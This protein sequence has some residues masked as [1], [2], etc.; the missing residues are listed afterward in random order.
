MTEETVRNIRLVALDLDDT[1][2]DSQYKLPPVNKKAV[3]EVLDLGIHVTFT[4]GR[5]YRSARPIAQEL[6]IKLPIITYQGAYIRNPQTGE[7]LHHAPLDYEDALEILELA[8]NKKLT[9]QAYFDDM[10]CVEAA[11]KYIAAYAV[12][13]NVPIKAVGDLTKFIKSPPTKLLLVGDP[14]ELD[15][16]WVSCNKKY[17]K[18]MYITKSKPYYLEFLNIISN[19][20]NGLS[21]LANSLGIKKEEIMAC[22]DS[23]NDLGLFAGAGLKVAMGNAIPELKAAADYISADNDN[24][25]VA[26]ALKK[27]VL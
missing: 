20:G 18:R 1:L 23:Y 25:G 12:A 26:Q 22:G 27:F 3:A 16:L 9:V 10:L 5:M 15:E 11:N 19:K 13:C 14:A 21:I 24:A 8:K 2:L 6:G 17:G 4:T 7:L